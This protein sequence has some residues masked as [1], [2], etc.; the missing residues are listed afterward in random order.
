LSEPA[1]YPKK[2]QKIKKDDLQEVEIKDINNIFLSLDVNK[3]YFVEIGC[4][5]FQTIPNLPYKVEN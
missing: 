3:E 1:E 4:N 5:K 2:T